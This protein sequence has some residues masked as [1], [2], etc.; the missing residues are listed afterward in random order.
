MPAVK[1]PTWSERPEGVGTAGVGLA[2]AWLRTLRRTDADGRI[3]GGYLELSIS[4]PAT[5]SLRLSDAELCA[6]V[7]LLERVADF[8]SDR[9]PISGA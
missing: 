1:H 3:G 7:C 9:A 8:G 6:F 4:S 2:L 5:C